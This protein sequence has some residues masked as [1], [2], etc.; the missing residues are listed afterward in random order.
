MYGDEMDAY[1]DVAATNLSAHDDATNYASSGGDNVSVLSQDTDKFDFVPPPKDHPLMFTSD[2]KR[3]IALLKFLDDMYAPDY[4]F[5]AISKW[6][7]AT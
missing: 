1:E 6:A 3:T 7:R 2:Q 4:A 5:E